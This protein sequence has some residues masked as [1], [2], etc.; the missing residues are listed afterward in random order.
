MS[1]VPPPGPN[2]AT[3]RGL[4]SALPSFIQGFAERRFGSKG[5]AVLIPRDSKVCNICG[6][7]HTKI[8]LAPSAEY[9]PAS[10]PCPRCQELLDQG[11]CAVVCGKEFAIFKPPADQLQD[12][13]G[14]VTPVGPAVMAAIKKRKNGPLNNGANTKSTPVD[15]GN[16]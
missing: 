3:L 10:E 7:A 16:N 12:W 15:P 1:E 5:K 11:C 9:V 8:P 14:K 2:R 6:V 4:R 13:I